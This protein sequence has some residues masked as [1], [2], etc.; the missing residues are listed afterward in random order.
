MG[1]SV[2]EVHA[3]ILKA[4]LCSGL[5]TNGSVRDLPKVAALEFPMFACSVSLSHSYVHLLDFG[6]P[7]EICGL[8][9]SPGDLLFGDVH[10]LLSIP[11]QIAADLPVVAQELIR[12]ERTIIDFCRSP[13]F[14][15]V[16]LRAIIE[17]L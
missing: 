1:A 2:G 3:E 9:I 13:D 11:L 7:V 5:V 10:G 16:K 4:L 14:S 6:V 17:K 15:V 12:K 8:K